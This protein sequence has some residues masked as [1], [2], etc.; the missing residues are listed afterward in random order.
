MHPITLNEACKRAG[1]LLDLWYTDPQEVLEILEASS[2]QTSSKV[3]N[4]GLW[5]NGLFRDKRDKPKNLEKIRHD[6]S[7]KSMFVD[8]R[9]ESLMLRCLRRCR[10]APAERSGVSRVKAPLPDDLRKELLDRKK[11]ADCEQHVDEWQKDSLHTGTVYKTAKP[12]MEVEFDSFPGRTFELQEGEYKR[13]DIDE[14]KQDNVIEALTGRLKRSLELRIVTSISCAIAG[15]LIPLGVLMQLQP[16]CVESLQN[17]FTRHFC[18]DLG[19]ADSTLFD[20]YFGLAV[21]AFSVALVCLMPVL[22]FIG[23]ELAAQAC[24]ASPRLFYTYRVVRKGWSNC[25]SDQ[26][27]IHLFGNVHGKASQVLALLLGSLYISGLLIAAIRMSPGVFAFSHQ[28]TLQM[29]R[30]ANII[31]GEPNGVMSVR[32]AKIIGILES[33]LDE[34]H[35]HLDK[36]QL[37]FELKQ[38]LSTPCNAGVVHVSLPF[39]ALLAHSSVLMPP[40]DPIRTQ[41]FVVKT[42]F[43]TYKHPVKELAQKDSQKDVIV[44]VFAGTCQVPNFCMDGERWQ[45]EGCLFPWHLSMEIW[46]VPELERKLCG[47]GVCCNGCKKTTGSSTGTVHDYGCDGCK[48]SNDLANRE[49]RPFCKMGCGRPAKLGLMK[50]GAG[51]F[52]WRST[53]NGLWAAREAEDM[54]ILK[55]ARAKQGFRIEKANIALNMMALDMEIG[56]QRHMLKPFIDGNADVNAEYQGETAL[57]RAARQN[58]LDI[59]LLLLESKADPTMMADRHGQKKAVDLFTDS[60]KQNH[61]KDLV[62]PFQEKANKVLKSDR[63]EMCRAEAILQDRDE[64]RL[65]EKEWGELTANLGEKKLRSSLEAWDAMLKEQAQRPFW[66]DPMYNEYASKPLPFGMLTDKDLQDIIESQEEARRCGDPY[67]TPSFLYW[68]ASI[69]DKMKCMAPDGSPSGYDKSSPEHQKW[70][71]TP[72]NGSAWNFFSKGRGEEITIP[73]KLAPTR[74]KPVALVKYVLT[75]KAERQKGEF[76]SERLKRDAFADRFLFSSEGKYQAEELSSEQWQDLRSGVEQGGPCGAYFTGADRGNHAKM[77]GGMD[78]PDFIKQAG[79]LDS[80]GWA[81]FMLNAWRLRDRDAKISETEGYDYKKFKVGAMLDNDFDLETGRALQGSS[82]MAAHGVHPLYLKQML[83]V[84]LVRGKFKSMTNKVPSF[85]SHKQFITL[86]GGVYT[87]TQVSKASQYSTAVNPEWVS[88]SAQDLH[89]AWDFEAYER[90]HKKEWGPKYPEGVMRKS[91]VYLLIVEVDVTNIFP[92][93]AGTP[94]LQRP[95][96]PMFEWASHYK[97]MQD[98]YKREWD[99]AVEEWKTQEKERRTRKEKQ[100]LT[101]AEIGKL[102]LQQRYDASRKQM[103]SES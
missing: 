31:V 53:R 11:H 24:P 69:P 16:L 68:Y 34:N 100:L 46:K 85:K 51:C 17:S 27:V 22:V 90:C 9:D 87:T 20:E 33:Q 86:G 42:G 55:S 82:V 83:D 74:V 101:A 84:G 30:I 25:V 1:C 38:F 64:R 7:E 10:Q 98:T 44:D 8:S 71:Q 59:A 92:L 48:D 60:A 21:G 47:E 79:D 56:D 97:K 29:M 102:L 91:P 45:R 35:V 23:G 50:P 39:L 14:S 81:P 80:Q 76:A 43:A 52:T 12:V 89:E 4:E 58:K 49:Q 72:F 66:K 93:Y 37:R 96:V 26:F 65:T 88:D 70:V 5:L 3:Q 6:V 2:K 18:D 13:C 63:F 41:K 54:R 94:D 78:L 73:W 62:V 15:C 77:T 19:F 57:Q 40:P 103:I 95:N 32:E 75:S 36:I 67:C 61:F 28:V 99:K